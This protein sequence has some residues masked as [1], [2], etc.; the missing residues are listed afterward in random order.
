MVLVFFHILQL[1]VKCRGIQWRD[2]ECWAL[3]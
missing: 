1:M 2:V 3:S